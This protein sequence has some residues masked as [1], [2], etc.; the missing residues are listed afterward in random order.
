MSHN[1]DYGFFYNIRQT[2][3]K[4]WCVVYKPA[5]KLFHHGYWPAEKEP[6]YQADLAK[7]EDTSTVSQPTKSTDATNT[8]SLNAQDLANQILSSKQGNVDA[9]VANTT[10][11]KQETSGA[12]KTSSEEPEIDLSKVDADA[13]ARANEIMARLAAEAAEDE[14]KKQAEIEDAKAK[15]RADEEAA[16]A[17]VKEDEAA[18]KARADEI[19][20][21]LAA[22]AAADEAKKQAEIDAAKAKAREDEM[23]AS[24]LKSTKVDIS[25]FIEEGKAQRQ[26]NG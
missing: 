3:Y 10:P 25:A 23:L 13:L 7:Q 1:N 20:A 11:L 22:E 24:I 4:W 2:V 19:M 26:D 6:Y 14:A 12:D 17:K 9:M 5:Y 15:A 8:S 16:K 18:A 21:R